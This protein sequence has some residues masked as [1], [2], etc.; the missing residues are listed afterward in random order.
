MATRL[1]A[2][3][4]EAF[5]EELGGNLNHLPHADPKEPGLKFDRHQREANQNILD[6]VE[7][8]RA[9]LCTVACCGSGKTA[10]EI[11][12][13]R[14]SQRAKQ[15]LGINGERKDLVITVGRAPAEAIREQFSDLGYETG[16]WMG[17]KRELEP[18]VIIANVHALQLSLVRK[19]LHRLLPQGTIDLAIYDEA[20]CFLTEH[21]K[22]IHKA[23]DA[24][25]G[26][27]LT[28]T[29]EWP[30]GRHIEELFG[31]EVHR[32]SLREG[33]LRGINAKP[34]FYLYEAGIDEDTLHIRKGDY[35]PTILAAA[36]RQAEIHRAIPEVY[37]DLIPET[38]R[39]EWP[40]LVYVP[41]VKLAQ[42][43][44]KTLTDTFPD[45]TVTVWTGEDMRSS[46]GLQ[47]GMETFKKG[48]IDI[49]VL[50]EMGGR[51]MNLENARVLIDGYPTLSLNKLEQR[52]GRVLRKIRPGGSALWNQGVRK[53][54]AIIAQIIPQ[55]R[56]HRRPALFTDVIGGYQEYHQMQEH[57]GESTGAPKSDMI[58]E[59]RRRIESR[60]PT[61]FV[62]LIE[63]I[64]V[65]H[66]IK[67]ID[68]LPHSDD[69]GFF[70][71]PR[72]YRKAGE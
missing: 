23:L 1:S 38:R 24:R 71:L 50:C 51:G 3:Y 13:I 69:T 14:S 55:N 44:Q 22:E 56:R 15:R 28:A 26:I 47:K 10:V 16:L 18:P 25:I 21:R 6:A 54:Q 43:T 45:L 31:R 12:L 62:R 64:N 20:D 4:R 68:E 2:A 30:D 52:H 65:V 59:I 57:F 7:G 67:R 36:L 53:E 41:S 5:L 40:T 37:R 70:S 27:G 49:L 61:H 58:D 39:H 66:E 11:G 34:D 29:P 48:E 32:L 33:I 35:D 19:Q 17:G 9:D 63:H 72:R 42:E 60:K 8:K 46:R